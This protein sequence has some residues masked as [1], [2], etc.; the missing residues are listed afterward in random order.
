M[1]IYII[2]RNRSKQIN[3]Q[4]NRKQIHNHQLLIGKQIKQINKQTINAYKI[5]KQAI[6]RY[7]TNRQTNINA[8]KANKQTKNEDK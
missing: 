5:N 3:K 6:D 4:T 2:Y 1:C 8:F 7:K